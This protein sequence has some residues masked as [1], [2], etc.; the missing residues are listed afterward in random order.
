MIFMSFLSSLA[1]PVL[2]FIIINLQYAF[3]AKG[4]EDDWEDRS[5]TYMTAMAIWV[6]WLIAISGG[7]KSIFM[8]MG[9]KMTYQIRLDLIEEIMHK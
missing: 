8:V 3:F 6:F 2:S 1:M 5:Y 4:V 7:S 9:E